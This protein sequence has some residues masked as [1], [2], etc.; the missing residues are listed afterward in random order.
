MDL[1]IEVMR[2]R[3]GPWATGAEAVDD[4]HTRWPIGGESFEALMASLAWVESG[5]DYQIEGNREFADYVEEA[6][7][8]ML[9]AATAGTERSVTPGVGHESSSENIT[10]R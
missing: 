4:T 6:A 9:R 5:V 7:E 2:A 10:K 1:P 3:F 8:R